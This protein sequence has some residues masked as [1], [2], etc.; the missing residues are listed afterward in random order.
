MMTFQDYV[1]DYAVSVTWGEYSSKWLRISKARRSPDTRSMYQTALDKLSPLND[2][3]LRSI[4]AFVIQSVVNDYW[5]LPVACSRIKLT[6]DQVFKRAVKDGL[7][8]IS[9]CPSDDVEYPHK[10][11]PCDKDTGAKRIL[12]DEE[13]FMLPQI[14]QQQTPPVRIMLLLL[15]AFGL[16][17]QEI[18]CLTKKKFDFNRMM[19]CIDCAVQ[20]KRK[21]MPA[22]VKSTKNGKVRYIPIPESVR[23]ELEEHLSKLGE[24]DYVVQ[25]KKGQMVSKGWITKRIRA[26]GEELEEALKHPLKPGFKPYTFRHNYATRI[27]YYEGVAKNLLSI[28]GA[29]YLMG[30][31]E[32]VFMN[33]Y[34]HLIKDWEKESLVVNTINGI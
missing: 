3:P 29:A 31:S 2:L 34:A 9:K 22:G 11:K 23:Q 18:P 10:K 24:D 28:K 6:V 16:R 19:L 21:D 14:R 27:L 5:E 20:W 12:T 15:Y 17:P 33:T 1:A 26:V 32:P 8:P 7:I 30:H 25:L 13:V 4:N